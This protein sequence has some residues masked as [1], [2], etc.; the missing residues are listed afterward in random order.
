MNSI[1]DD[2]FIGYSNSTALYKLE[3]MSMLV[4]G[5]MLVNWRY[6]L[7]VHFSSMF[8]FRTANFATAGIVDQASTQETASVR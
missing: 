3:T 5:A 2:T 6:L 1:P 8:Y 7:T 4:A